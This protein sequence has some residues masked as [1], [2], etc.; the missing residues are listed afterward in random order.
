[1]P[2]N[3]GFTLVELM[4]TITVMA[5]LI[6]VAVP[7]FQGM[8]Q[9]HR[10]STTANQLITGLLFARSEAVKRGE[11]VS[12]CPLNSAW[13]GSGGGWQVRVGNDCSGEQLR[14]WERLPANTD[15]SANFSSGNRV[16]FGALGDRVSAGSGG[17]GNH[18]FRVEPQSCTGERAREIFV[19]RGGAASVGRSPCSS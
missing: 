4:I 2:R 15:V 8:I 16:T 5:I 19:G 6:G 14:V 13:S 9:N 18:L 12:L 10:A 17:D 7:G 11:Q 1:M 3:G